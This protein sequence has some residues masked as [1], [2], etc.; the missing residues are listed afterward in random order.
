MRNHLEDLDMAKK[1]LISAGFFLTNQWFCHCSNN[2]A[3]MH[4]YARIA[5]T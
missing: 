2:L 3:L 5:L 1:N 4:D